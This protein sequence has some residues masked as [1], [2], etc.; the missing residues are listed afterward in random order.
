MNERRR[1][2]RVDFDG[3]AELLFEQD[4]HDVE[5]QDISISGARVICTT[6]LALPDDASVTLQIAFDDSDLTLTLPGRVIRQAA[7]E[8]GIHFERP[9]VD[10][11][12]HL[13]RLVALQQ[14]EAGDDDP[15]SILSE[16]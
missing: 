3:E 16:D 13:R 6:P 8:V 12:Q 14:G 1:A 4:R 9:D 2:G 10:V 7:M 11:M 15:A 5:L